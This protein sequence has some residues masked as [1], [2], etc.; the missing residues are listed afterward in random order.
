MVEV[1]RY[2]PARV[3][4]SGIG[5]LIAAAIVLGLASLIVFILIRGTTA[6]PTAS[7]PPPWAFG[8]IAGLFGFFGLLLLAGAVGRVVSAFA[9][10]CCI[11]ASPD[12]MVLRFP[13]RGWFGR[14]SVREFRWR[15]SSI[16][17]LVH[18]T[19]KING[20]PTST[21]LR[22]ELTDGSRVKIERYNFSD[23]SAV[24][25]E[26]LLAIKARAR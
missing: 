15:W 12:G 16:R 19:H 11:W 6:P 3:I 17:Q 2:A 1:A 24:I 26:R 22:I 20:I 23:S 9:R 7:D 4:V 8:V 13:V 10:G 25:Q 18:M 14:F 21:E 5:R